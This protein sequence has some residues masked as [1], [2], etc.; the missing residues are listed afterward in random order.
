VGGPLPGVFTSFRV[1]REKR[2]RNKKKR[3]DGRTG[4]WKYQQH[5]EQVVVGSSK[6][7]GATSTTRRRKKKTKLQKEK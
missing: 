6:A 3:T 7:P 4:V 5:R 2:K 1:E